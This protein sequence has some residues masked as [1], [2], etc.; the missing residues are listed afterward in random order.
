MSAE[1]T[2]SDPYEAVLA[3][4]RAKRAQLDQAIAAIEAIRSG[5]P[6]PGVGTS[7]NRRLDTRHLLSPYEV[8][9]FPQ[10]LA[11][12][13]PGHRDIGHQQ[14]YLDGAQLIAR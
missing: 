4:L 2:Y 3:D 14:R 12:I 10:P 1:S 13:A 11:A 5:T 7:T 9:D 6:I 8:V